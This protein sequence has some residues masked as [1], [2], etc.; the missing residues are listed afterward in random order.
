MKFAI[1][2]SIV[3][4]TSFFLLL[5]VLE[6]RAENRVQ[7]YHR[8]FGGQIYPSP[9]NAVKSAVSRPKL[10]KR[11]NQYRKYTAEEEERLI[12][13]RAQE[14]S[15]A[16]IAES[17][18]DRNWQALRAKHTKLTKDRSAKARKTNRWTE[19]EESILLE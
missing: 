9:V 2:S 6:V 15:W 5:Y 1:I 11:A 17:F 19:G 18:P 16:E 7:S 14:Y 3:L 13:L 10:L 8:Q 12:R 4:G